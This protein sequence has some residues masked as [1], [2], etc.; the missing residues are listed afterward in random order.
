[1]KMFKT[2]TATAAIAALVS[3]TSCT[4]VL[5]ADNDQLAEKG[6]TKQSVELFNTYGEGPSGL[7][8]KT[9]ENIM[10][11]GIDDK[12]GEAIYSSEDSAKIDFKAVNNL[13]RATWLDKKLISLNGTK[14]AAV[15]SA[16]F[17]GVTKSVRTF[18]RKLKGI[19]DTASSSVLT[20]SESSP[21]F[22]AKL[23]N[24][25]GYCLANITEIDTAFADSSATNTGVV[26]IDYFYI[27]N[28]DAVDTTS[29]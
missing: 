1:M 5:D 7:D 8:A 11:S 12:T 9:G 20:Y 4:D 19:A 24:N 22:V 14:Y 17:E 26:K 21:Y 6:I 2:L 3:L 27:S 28:E 23:G 25:R 15:D 18:A 29:N 10:A 16:D 13:G